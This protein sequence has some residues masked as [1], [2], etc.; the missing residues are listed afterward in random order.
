MKKDKNNIQNKILK[1]SFSGR[2]FKSGAYVSIVS[3]VVIALVLIINLIIT[4]FDLRIDLSSEGF[5]TLTDETKEYVKNIEDNITIYY[6]VEAGD[7]L[8]M[9]HKIAQKFDSL[10]NHITLQQKDPIQYPSFVAEYIDVDEQLELNSFLVV[11]NSTN[12]A[13]YVNYNDMLVKEL[14]QQTYKINTVGIDVEGKLI[15]A[16]QYVTNPDLPTVYYTLGHDEYEVGELFKDTIDR[17]NIAINPLQTITIDRIPEDCDTLIIN[18]PKRDFSDSEIELIKQYMVSG[19]NAVIVMD[20]QAQ[21]FDNLN[22]L[23]NYYGIQMERGIISEADGNYYI[24]LYPRY[25][26]PRILEHDITNGLYNSNRYVVAPVSSGLTIM[27]NIRSSLS[28][29]PLMETSKQAYSKV[30]IN[31]ETL[32]K[33]KGDIDGPFYVGA[34]STDTFDGVTSNLVVYTSAMIFNDN[35]LSEFSNFN[36]M[37]NTIGNFVR[38]IETITVRPRSLYPKPLNITQQSLVFWAALTIIVLP[39]II[40][41][42]GTFI[43]V[44]RRRQ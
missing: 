28:I 9:I 21:N 41:A 24:P 40:L 3:A 38:D 13:K 20:Y 4:E 14:S 36:L 18:A 26:V 35:M 34:I 12:R 30:N 23:V 8:A 37:T 11:N 29:T 43:I 15:S 10:S 19:G 39:L 33:E 27:D 1:A 6:L 44:R 25:L 7:E 31:A 42:T 16:I 2:K 17:M 32:L 5:Y 22:S